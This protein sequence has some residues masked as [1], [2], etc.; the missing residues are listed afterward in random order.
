MG[1]DQAHTGALVAHS[2]R[3]GPKP[4]GIGL[5]LAWPID[6]IWSRWGIN[7]A[8]IQIPCSFGGT[9]KVGLSSFDHGQWLGAHIPGVDAFTDPSVTWDYPPTA[10][11]QP[12]NG[13]QTPNDRTRNT[14]TPTRT[15][16]V[17]TCWKLCEW[18]GRD[19]RGFGRP[20]GQECG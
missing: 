13:C 14:R 10:C 4:I 18:I 20:L 3:A 16:F 15:S 2:V 17:R 12:L 6:Q 9:L 11:P 5:L 8:D 1:R 19:L 7:L